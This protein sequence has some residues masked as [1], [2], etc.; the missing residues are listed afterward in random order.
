MM[1]SMNRLAAAGAAAAGA[2]L[3]AM[4]AGHAQTPD[5]V[6]SRQRRPEAA[7]RF[8]RRRGRRRQSDRA[9]PGGRAQWR[10]LRLAPGWRPARRDAGQRRRRGAARQGRRRTPRDQRRVRDRQRHR[11][12]ASK[13][14]SVPG[15]VQLGRALQDDARPAEAGE[16]NPRSGR[17]RSA[18]RAAARRQGDRVR[19]QG[20]LV[21]ERRRAVECLPGSG[22]ASWRQGTGSLPVAREER[23][24]LEVRREQAR[25]DTGGRHALGDR[26]CARCRASPTTTTRCTSR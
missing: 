15:Q 26:T 21:R 16:R 25:P 17:Q 13:R 18:R 1:S 12:R 6:R 9:T 2:V 3:L 10:R 14:L 24:H 8:L 4:A 23:R 20:R 5:Q 7:G 19:R 22:S 11:H